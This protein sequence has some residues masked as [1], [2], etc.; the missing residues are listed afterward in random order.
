MVMGDAVRACYFPPKAPPQQAAAAAAAAAGKN[1]LLLHD[2]GQVQS[3]GGGGEGGVHRSKL[4]LVR[5]TPLFAPFMY[6]NEHFTKTG[7]GQT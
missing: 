4:M 7:S 1:V 6:K 3:G 5:K 2:E